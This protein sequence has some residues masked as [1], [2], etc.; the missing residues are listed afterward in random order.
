MGHEPGLVPARR[1]H[2]IEVQV[3]VSDMAEGHRAAAGQG[4]VH[5]GET[6]RHEG[7]DLAHRHRDVVLDRGTLALLRLGVVLAQRP[8]GA[9]LGLVL[10]DG[11]VEHETLLHRLAEIGLHLLAQALLAVPSRACRRP[12]EQHVP[13]V[14]LGQRIDRAGDVLQHEVDALAA[15]PLAGG[16]IVLA[17]GVGAAQQLDG[18]FR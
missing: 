16:D 17:G 8:E 5:R 12:F 15:H 14:V 3:A 6:F 13:G 10:G 7:G 9:R 18:G 2:A 11:G 1:R 4:L